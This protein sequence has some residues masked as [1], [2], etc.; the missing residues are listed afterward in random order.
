[1][2]REITGFSREVAVLLLRHS[3][4]GNVRELENAMERS[5]A[6]AQGTR[7]ELADLPDELHA[8]VHEPSLGRTGEVQP[9]REIEKQYIL[10]VLSFNKGNRS[11]TARQLDIGTAT[12]YRKLKAYAETGKRDGA[13]A[14]D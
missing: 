3:W 1:M 5:V 4:P 6:L 13:S 7:V 8:V 2:A 9:L 12:L 14:G 11:D 10:S